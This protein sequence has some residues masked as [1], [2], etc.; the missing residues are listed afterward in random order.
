[1]IVPDHWAEARKQHRSAAQ[2]F[3]VRRFGWSNTSPADAERMAEARAEEALQGLIAGQA[4][5][6][7]EPKVAYNGATGTPIREEVLA[8]HGEHVITRNAYGAR[9]LNTA[10]VLF[11]DI[12]FSPPGTGLRPFAMAFAPLAVMA[13]ATGVAMGS[14]VVAMGLLLL[15]LALAAPAAR[16]LARRTVAAAGGP[17]GMARERLSRF[18]AQHPDW[19]L[20]LY[21]TPAGLRVLATHAPLDPRSDAVQA[22]F[23]QVAADPV[24]VRMCMSQ[25]CFRARLSAKPWRIGISQGLRPRPGVWPVRPEALAARQAWVTHYEQQAAAYAAC[26]YL[27]AIGS[28]TVHATAAPVVDLHDRESRALSGAPQA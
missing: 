4:L 24:Y 9:C 3:T 19:N 7:R 28:G 17:E 8:R 23:T 21:R 25:N 13:L 27:G 15:A 18:V 5:A 22:F 26:H 14:S 11:A 2:R 10:N 6:R 1:M 20:R 16:L 12:D